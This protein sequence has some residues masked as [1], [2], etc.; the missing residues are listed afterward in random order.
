MLDLFLRHDDTDVAVYTLQKDAVSIFEAANLLLQ[1]FK[2]V[3]MSQNVLLVEL[4]ADTYFRHLLVTIELEHFLE[5]R[6]LPFQK[7]L[8]LILC[9]VYVAQDHAHSILVYDFEHGADVR[10]TLKALEIKL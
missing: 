6:L 10:D 4:E 3:E 5:V 9:L 7:A 1:P 8:G 2:S